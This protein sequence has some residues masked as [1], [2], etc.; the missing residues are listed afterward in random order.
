MEVNKVTRTTLDKTKAKPEIAKEKTSFTEVMASKRTDLV[1]AKLQKLMEDIE[2]QGSVLSE[3][4]TVDDLRR[5]KKLVREFLDESVKNALAIE[6]RRGFNRRGRTKIYKVVAEVDKK[7]LELTDA[8]LQKQ[9]KGLRILDL[10][11][12]IKGLLIN[13][14][15]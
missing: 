9:E 6:E 2:D 11:G 8:V 12:E 4:Q 5:Y 7:L 15:A 3:S 14:Y 10:V 1:M 13:V